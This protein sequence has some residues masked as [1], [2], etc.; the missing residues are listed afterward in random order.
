MQEF[1]SPFPRPHALS[2]EEDLLQGYVNSS[3]DPLATI[4]LSNS[5]SSSAKI[6]ESPE[7]NVLKDDIDKSVPGGGNI[8]ET[9]PVVAT[10]VPPPST[11]SH[12]SKKQEQWVTLAVLFVNQIIFSMMHGM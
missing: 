8:L 6:A 3:N 10:Y 12:L 7:A 9:K 1:P 2:Q 4:D 5:L 11:T